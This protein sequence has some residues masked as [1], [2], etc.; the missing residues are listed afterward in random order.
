MHGSARQGLSKRGNPRVE[1]EGQTIDGMIAAFMEEHRIPGMALAIVQAPY[2]SRAAGYGVSDPA[3]RLLASPKTLWNVGQMTQAFTAVAVVQLVEAGRLGLDDP[4]GNHVPGLPAPWRP[5]TV[6]QLLAHVSGLPDYTRQAGF[7]PAREYERGEVLGLVKDTPP[8]FPP[9]TQV[10]DSATDFFLL[11]L[12]VEGASGMG[13]EAFVT[14]NQVERLGLKNT[15]FAS[16]LTGVRQEAVERNDFR[17]QA[18]L[19][20]RPYI[21]PTEVAAGCTERDGKAVPV[22]RNSQGGWYAN[23]AL[24]AS[25]EDISL[26][27]VGLAGDLLVSRKE[28]RAFLYG[29][30]TLSDGTVVPA[31]CGWRFPRHRGLMD[32]RGRVPGFSCYLSRFTD[33]D[34]LVCVTLCANKDGVDLVELARRIAGAFD[35]RLGPPAA[36]A[37]MTCLESCYPV[38]ATLDRLEAF[39]KSKGVA[40]A[41]RVDHAA[42]ARGKGLELRPT[43][44]LVFGNPA[45][46]THLMRSRQGIALDLPLRVAAWE[47]ADG[48]VW[49]GYHDVADLAHR[50]GIADRAEVVEGMRAGLAAALDHATAPY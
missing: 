9:G 12:V 5:V 37:V 21:D 6:R 1:F 26:W 4:V 28:N 23:G 48:T 24:L 32:I 45:V 18:F 44:V 29:G 36:P 40:V 10:A 33:R 8:A 7:D 15:L 43:E 3:R 35:H 34:D 2:I 39:L 49:V 25:V 17:H 30:V 16:A 14:R 50:H 20:E 41:V 31:H 27:D 47:E 13:Y 19:R 11:G 22:P 42:A 38:A 46:G